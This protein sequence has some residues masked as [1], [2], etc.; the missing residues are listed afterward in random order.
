MFSDYDNLLQECF[1][2]C[3]DFRRLSEMSREMFDKKTFEK[4]KLDLIYSCVFSK[5]WKF[6]EM[7]QTI[8]KDAHTVFGLVRISKQTN[9]VDLDN[10]I[11]LWIFDIWLRK[12]ESIQAKEDHPKFGLPLWPQTHP[13][14]P[15]QPWKLQHELVAAGARAPRKAWPPQ[16][17]SRAREVW[18]SPTFFLGFWKTAA[19][20]FT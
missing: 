11:Q 10:S 19:H 2:K 5:S 12:S 18:N 17:T 13:G 7:S 20:N 9:R 15:K 8:H 3:V 16:P 6:T 1:A 4:Q 14:P